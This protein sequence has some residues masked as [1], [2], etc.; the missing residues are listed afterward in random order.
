M[1]RRTRDE[2]GD[3]D[4]ESKVPFRLVTRFNFYLIMI[5]LDCNF[6]PAVFLRRD[7]YPRPAW[8][9]SNR[10]WPFHWI[11]VICRNDLLANETII[12]KITW[13]SHWRISVVILKRTN[14]QEFR[15][16]CSIHSSRIRQ[17]DPE[18]LSI[19]Y[20]ATHDQMILTCSEKALLRFLLNICSAWVLA[21]IPRPWTMAMSGRHSNLQI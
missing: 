4:L 7:S 20:Q 1:S 2:R 21:G 9:R 15:K 18:A 12:S 5:W 16:A 3:D 17:C 11:I 14:F 6:V 13:S 10:S 19:R 8:R